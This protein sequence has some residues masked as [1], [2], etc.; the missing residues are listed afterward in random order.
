M[1]VQPHFCKSQ[2]A[3]HHAS[4]APEDVRLGMFGLAAV[5]V[6]EMPMQEGGVTFCLTPSNLGPLPNLLLDQAGL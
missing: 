3:Q 4:A 2:A 6:P 1:A 5:M